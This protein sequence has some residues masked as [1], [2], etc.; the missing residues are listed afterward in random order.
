[1]I[2]NIAIPMV[3]LCGLAGCWT[4][5]PEPTLPDNIEN[6]SVIVTEG[7]QLKDAVITAANR[8]RWTPV[9]RDD[10]TI[11]CE[12]VQRSH[13]VV[14]DVILLDERHYSIQMVESN[15]P[16]RKVAQWVNNLQREIA[17]YA[18]AK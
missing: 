5:T 2:K 8:R 4:T 18:A 15:I 17:K 7:H 16:S 1:M 3:A 12:L 10:K 13:K 6:V 9:E 14:V 11:R